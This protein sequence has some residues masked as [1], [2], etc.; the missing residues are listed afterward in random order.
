MLTLQFGHA[1]T[2]PQIW[3][4]KKL[5]NPRRFR[6][7]MLCPPDFRFSLS[8]ATRADDSGTGGGPE[9][10]AGAAGGAAPLPALTRFASAD[11]RA[12]AISRRISTISTVAIARS[13]T[14]RK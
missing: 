11:L 12:S 8:A 9:S 7:T 3:H 4:C 14:R 5:W 10:L 6:N 2:L 1:I 13:L